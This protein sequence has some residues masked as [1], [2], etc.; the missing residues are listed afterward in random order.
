MKLNQNALDNF[1]KKAEDLL[2]GINVE[3]IPAKKISKRKGFSPDVHISA[4]I[5]P[6]GDIY[7][8]KGDGSGNI[9]SRAV[10]FNSQILKVDG[11]EYQKLKQ[12]AQAIQRTPDFQKSVSVDFLTNLIFEWVK[13]TYKKETSLSMI[14]YV[15]LECE[16]KFKSGKFGYRSH[17][18]ISNLNSNLEISNSR[19]LPERC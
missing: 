12:L 19:Q 11:E 2:N 16:K 18:R 10:H 14:D 4:K 17:T 9:T 15:I 1:N 8:S 6:I 13:D 3:P 5:K 7:T